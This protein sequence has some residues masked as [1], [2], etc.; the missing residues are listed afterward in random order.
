MDVVT[1]PIGSE[2]IRTGAVAAAVVGVMCGVVGCYVVLRGMAL[3]AEGLAHG[4]MPGVG[5]AFALT[6]GAAG[7]SPDDLAL[8]VGA[9]IAAVVTAVGT[10]AVLSRGRLREDTAAAVVFVFMLA[11]GVAIV[12]AVETGDAHL[13]EFLF[14]DVT[15]VSWGEVGVAAVVTLVILGLVAVLY[16]PFLLLSFDRKRAAAIGMPVERLQLLMLVILALAVVIGFRVV[17]V[18]LVLG[19]LIAPAAAAA[20]VTKRL[21]AM[22]AVSAA[23]AA[24]SGPLGLIASWHLDV[25]AGPAIVLVAVA[26]FGATLA[27]RPAAR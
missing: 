24:L 16:R 27:V 5:I 18:L 10:N 20:L 3:V 9:L 19:L 25:A 11:L 4:V 23:I 12:S 21:P 13:E 26:A 22:M 1:D 7:T 8:T 14:G 2:A 6:A 17:G 15:G